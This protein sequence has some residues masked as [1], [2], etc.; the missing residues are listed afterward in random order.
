MVH[1]YLH[2]KF[3]V[4][5]RNFFGSAKYMN[6]QRGDA[7]VNKLTVLIVMMLGFWLLSSYSRDHG[8]DHLAMSDVGSSN[9]RPIPGNVTTETLT[10][11]V[12]SLTLINKIMGRH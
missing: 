2:F 12:S 7:G 3:K 10:N 1:L 11:T 8:G 4:L 9:A 6:N 5:G